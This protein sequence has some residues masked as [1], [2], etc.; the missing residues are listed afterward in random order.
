MPKL[1]P[2]EG[3]AS[4]VS[5]LVCANPEGFGNDAVLGMDMRS[6][7]I[8]DAE[9]L[10]IRD[11]GITPSKQ[12]D[13]SRPAL[14]TQE[15]PPSVD[16]F[17]DE[18]MEDLR[19]I[20]SMNEDAAAA[21]PDWSEVRPVAPKST[22]RRAASMP[23]PDSTKVSSAQGSLLWRSAFCCGGCGPR[24]S[25]CLDGNNCGTFS[26]IR[27]EAFP[28]VSLPNPDLWDDPQSAPE[29]D[30]SPRESD[31]VEAGLH[32]P[33]PMPELD[34][35]EARQLQNMHE[36]MLL[37][38]DKGEL[39][40]A[41]DLGERLL[42][43]RGLKQGPEHL[44]CLRLASSLGSIFQG[45]GMLD[46]AE[47]LFQQVLHGLD[48]V[49][50]SDHIET[51]R[52]VNDIACV[53]EAKGKHRAAERLSRLLLERL[54]E[55]LGTG[56]PETARCAEN[57]GSLLEE[58]GHFEAAEP[59]YRMAA[60]AFT[61]ALGA[62][63]SQTVA[64]RYRLACA[65]EAKGSLSDAVPIFREVLAANEAKLGPDHI[66]TR[67]TVY[68]LALALEALGRC[69]EA[70]SLFRHELS[71]CERI[72]GIHHRNTRG[73]RRNLARFLEAQG[74][75]QEAKE[76]VQ[77]FAS[78]KS[79]GSPPGNYRGCRASHAARRRCSL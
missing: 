52:A 24:S 58:Q 45:M 69:A 17:M 76:L 67:G 1:I 21:I 56:H 51:L 7:Y 27:V 47:K 68:S 34:P 18:V 28:A 5:D 11:E 2:P 39:Q 77:R 6:G 30:S 8:D 26:T 25:T 66:E 12:G 9:I 41:V 75:H 60:E 50:G 64:S 46:K 40:E 62:E 61:D 48:S 4:A 3:T 23:S 78:P 35:D 33:C 36:E 32:E 43:L 16:T 72:D 70:E 38:Q 57:L 31:A 14:L 63:H 53:L 74:R 37:L 49:L 65:L 20:D 13:L 73:S 29:I 79:M 42:K 19:F 15:R 22:S 54:T 10:A 71:G 55:V 44:D 59:F